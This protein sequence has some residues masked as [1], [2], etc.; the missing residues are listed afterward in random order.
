[1]TRAAKDKFQKS[2]FFFVSDD[3]VRLLY[4]DISTIVT[5]LV[6]S[7]VGSVMLSL[8]SVFMSGSLGG[9]PGHILVFFGVSFPI[10]KL[11]IVRA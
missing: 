3:A 1:M 9:Q 5:F 11:F 7:C 10:T 4:F 2:V 8:G 6:S